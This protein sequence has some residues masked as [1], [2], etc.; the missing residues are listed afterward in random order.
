M[1]VAVA[2]VLLICPV[3]VARV[4]AVSAQDATPAPGPDPGIAVAHPVVGTWRWENDRLHPG[5][6]SFAA[7]H[8]DGTYVEFYPGYGVGIGA[9]EATGEDSASL[10]IVFQ[11]LDHSP[12]VV[13]PGLLTYRLAITADDGGE[14]LRATG[15]FYL[16][17]PDG[18][19]VEERAFDGVATRVAVIPTGP[20][21][22]PPLTAT[23]P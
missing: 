19:V 4:L 2:A 8:A 18:E 22:V 1:T 11:D 6:A 9:W 23:T 21:P 15:T 17:S 16:Q 13:V 14:S 12:T 3:A 7:I 5:D 20:F 10:S